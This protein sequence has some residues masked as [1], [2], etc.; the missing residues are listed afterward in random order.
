MLEENPWRDKALELL[1]VAETNPVPEERLHYQLAAVALMD[2]AENAENPQAAVC[3]DCRSPNTRPMDCT[4]HG[5]SAVL[6]IT[7]GAVACISWS[8]IRCSG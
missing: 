1:S 7:D 4:G 5:R 6:G 2:I 3:T 8:R